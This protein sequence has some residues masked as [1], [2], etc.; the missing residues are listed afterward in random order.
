MPARVLVPHGQ[1]WRVYGS[2]E[3]IGGG[4]TWQRPSGAGYTQIEDLTG[5][6][7]MAKIN[8]TPNGNIC[9][10]PAATFSQANFSY[11]AGGN[12]GICYLPFQPVAG[13]A[14][15]GIDQTFLEITPGSSDRASTIP[16][17]STG[18]V[19]PGNPGTVNQL[20]LFRLGEAPGD[21]PAYQVRYI[22]GMTIR[23]TDQPIYTID[24]TP[25]FATGN[26]HCY[27][28]VYVYKGINTIIE[29]TKIKAIPGSY[30]ANPGE[31]YSINLYRTAGAMIRRVEV[32][33]RNAAGVRFGGTGI[34]NNT[35]TGSNAYEDVYIHDMKWG[36]GVA[37]Y[38]VYGS[39]SYTRTKIEKVYLAAWNFE[40]CASSAFTVEMVDCTVGDIGG[41]AR[42]GTSYAG[43]PIWAILDSDVG[44][45]TV[46]IRNPKVP[47]GAGNFVSPSA[48]R[49]ILIVI[50]ST[51]GG[52]TNKQSINDVHVFD[53]NGVEQPTWKVRL[54][55]YQ[56]GDGGLM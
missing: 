17:Q 49:P 23:G 44:S 7:V 33:G 38:N 8:A 37:H 21:N 19:S 30:G 54:T 24:D 16:P 18:F 6:T 40:H 42:T 4:Q 14:G 29:D 34:G 32:D 10:F 20:T 55:G 13:V 47:D 51:Y 56:D 27:F 50:H 9:T 1:D 31:T 52:V 25:G 41:R 39:V 36:H 43:Q 12:Y 3:T 45:A 5:A 28:G 35:N 26:P 2:N 46:N 53:A 22:G 11:G 48:A 15:S